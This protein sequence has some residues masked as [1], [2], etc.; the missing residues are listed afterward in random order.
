MN[1]FISFAS[2]IAIT[3]RVKF[4]L[5][6]ATNEEM[7]SADKKRHPIADDWDSEHLNEAKTYNKKQDH[8]SP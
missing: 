8:S 1:E 4:N 6:R 7:H 5:N 3:F 2:T